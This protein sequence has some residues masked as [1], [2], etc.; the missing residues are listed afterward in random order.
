V[1]L[2][3]L[4]RPPV[5]QLIVL[6]PRLSVAAVAG[7]LVALGLNTATAFADA[8]GYCSQPGCIQHQTPGA[9]GSNAQNGSGAASG[10]FGA[11][12]T[13]GDVPRVDPVTGDPT[14]KHDQGHVTTVLNPDGTTSLDPR[15]ADGP[16]TGAANSGVTG[17]NGKKP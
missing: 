7:P 3:P 15:G 13:F 17:N 1:V 10:A 12:G 2:N 6:T 5:S 8:G 4:L 9:P 14:T 11:F 16:A